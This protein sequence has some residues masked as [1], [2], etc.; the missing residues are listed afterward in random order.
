MT[1]SSGKGRVGDWRGILNFMKATEGI[2]RH[3]ESIKTYHSHMPLI[4]RVSLFRDYICSL[5]FDDSVFYT[6]DLQYGTR[7]RTKGSIAKDR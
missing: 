6:L 2:R 5:V 4:D 3:A 1:I 7:C